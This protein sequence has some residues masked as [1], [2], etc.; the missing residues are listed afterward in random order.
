MSIKSS[1]ISFVLRAL[2]VVMA[3]CW[4]LTATATS[5]DDDALVQ[6]AMS[7]DYQ[8]AQAL[9]A[10]GANVNAKDPEGM[11]A[12]MEASEKWH[13]EIAEL[14]LSKGADVNAK[15]KHGFTA[16]LRS[17]K[18]S[19]K[20]NPNG[21]YQIQLNGKLERYD[22][23]YTGNLDII[24]LLLVNG[25]DINAKDT[26]GRTAL[27]IAAITG[28][29]AITELLLNKGANANDKDKN[30][31]TALMTTVN[32]GQREMSEL[33]LAKGANVNDQTT[34][35]IT[36]LMIAA[37][38][39]YREEIELLLRKG[40]DVNAK[41]TAGR[42]ALMF[43][44]GDNK[45][46]IVELLLANGAD[47]NAKRTDGGTALFF[48]SYQG[49]ADLVKLLLSKGADVNIKDNN[50]ITPLEVA[51][52]K[53]KTDVVELLKKAGAKEAQ[54]STSNNSKQ[55]LNIEPAMV[56]IPGK[57][58][59][60]GKYDVTQREWKAVMG[61]N[62]SFFSSCGENCP[63]ENVSWDG[64][65]QFIQKLNTK[66]GKQY[67]LP[68]QEEWEYACYGGNQTEY[69]GGNDINAV[70]WYSDNSGGQTHPVGQ[71]QAN[72]YGIYDMSGNVQ[73]WMQDW[74]NKNL[75][76]RALRGGSWIF[77]PERERATSIG[78][79]IPFI[80]ETDTGFR[81]ARTIP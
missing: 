45:L 20:N 43:N 44:I 63:V 57:N 48:A 17:F 7:G 77:K 29:R 75:Q 49:N 1:S 66:T 59:E 19:G 76:L 8:A 73:Q 21:R 5:E 41:D 52:Q 67:R 22:F 26:N 24:K 28:D 30:G 72:G 6:A 2:L 15:D 9:I 50:G 47:V 74:N 35:G 80:P 39:G 46:D 42:T 79:M 65:Q 53:G 70:A 10:N 18:M 54:P 12:L 4:A 71:K 64:V 40:A 37:Q 32:N 25:A 61:N 78:G 55:A 60:I 27:I 16:L 62:P 11:T 3:F 34:S 81:L 58:Y 14:L 36:A 51:T 23:V 33:L 31:N 68:T 69:C 56:A 13:R 38:K